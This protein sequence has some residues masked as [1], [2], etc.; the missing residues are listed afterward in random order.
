M[1]P[2]EAQN[3]T[4]CRNPRL[5]VSTQQPCGFAMEG[6]SGVARPT[7]LFV[8]YCHTGGG[9]KK[10]EKRRWL[11]R[12]ILPRCI[13]LGLERRSSHAVSVLKRHAGWLDQ[14]REFLPH[15]RERGVARPPHFSRWDYLWQ[16]TWTC[17]RHGK[18]ACRRRSA[19]L[20]ETHVPAQDRSPP[21]QLAPKRPSSCQVSP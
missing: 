18:T 7:R 15:Q 4:R 1:T 14:T 2:K 12:H 11:S 13:S 17:A 21:F 3:S 6:A 16:P 10:G 20:L 8:A 5:R 9:S 19:A